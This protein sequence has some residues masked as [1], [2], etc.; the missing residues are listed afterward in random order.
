[1]WKQTFLLKGTLPESLVWL[2]LI[3]LKNMCSLAHHGSAYHGNEDTS[4]ELL[5]RYD[6]TFILAEKIR[7]S[8][9]MKIDALGP[10]EQGD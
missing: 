4:C 9:V 5:N 8:I 3:G 10:R 1:M 7:G 2:E 6:Y